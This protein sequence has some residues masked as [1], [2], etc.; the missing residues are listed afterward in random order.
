[1][2][3]AAI[4]NICMYVRGVLLLYNCGLT[5]N[6]YL[7]FGE[8]LLL[9]NPPLRPAHIPMDV[10]QDFSYNTLHYFESEDVAA[11]FV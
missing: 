1:M 6:K 5:N 9:L 8:K 10:Q 4:K 7:Y 2:K 11:R 3:V